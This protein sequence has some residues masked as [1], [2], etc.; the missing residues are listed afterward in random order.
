MNQSTSIKVLIPPGAS[1]VFVIH[2]GKRR[3]YAK[4]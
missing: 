3:I 4:P 1:T 2:K